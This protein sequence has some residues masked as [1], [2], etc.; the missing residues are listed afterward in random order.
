MRIGEKQ[1]NDMVNTINTMI[2]QPSEPYTRGA[3]G[4]C[5]ILP[6]PCRLETLFF[7]T[8][9]LNLEKYFLRLRLCIRWRKRHGQQTRLWLLWETGL[10]F[11]TSSLFVSS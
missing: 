7:Q 3:A 11:P 10:I 9:L 6:M 2:G 5:A 8:Q 4:L 1:L